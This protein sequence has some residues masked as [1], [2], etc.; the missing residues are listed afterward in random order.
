M[1]VQ[2][3]TVTVEKYFRVKNWVRTTRLYHAVESS[4]SALQISLKY[5]DWSKQTEN[6]WSLGCTQSL[7]G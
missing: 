3:N 6:D 1:F 5:P 4:M 7:L 2:K